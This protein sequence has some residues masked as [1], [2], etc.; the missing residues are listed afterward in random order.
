VIV[1]LALAPI[2]TGRVAEQVA[3]TA[4]LVGVLL[5]GFRLTGK[6]ELSQFN[7]YDLAMLMALS[8]AVQNAMT[9]GL[10]NLPIG[11]A[12]SSTVVLVAWVISKVLARRPTLERR[13]LGTPTLLVSDGQPLPGPMAR[14]R[15]SPEQLDEACR[16]RGVEDPS[17]CDLV[18]LEIDGS[19]S[20]VPREQ[21]DRG[22]RSERGPSRRRGRRRSR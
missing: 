6:R 7:V 8:N 17:D 9:G 18:V 15:V 1:D 10:G 20:V 2:S 13:V 3:K 22:P 12:V 21:V 19:V 14:A 11:L 16:E 4:I 5:V